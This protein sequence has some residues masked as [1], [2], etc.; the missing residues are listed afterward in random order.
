ML[1][2]FLAFILHQEVYNFYFRSLWI[3][4]VTFSG[5]ALYCQCL[6]L[7]GCQLPFIIPSVHSF[8]GSRQKVN[9]FWQCF[10]MFFC[11]CSFL[12]FVLYFP[13]SFGCWAHSDR[14]YYS[15]C[16]MSMSVL[17]YWKNLTK[18]S[19]LETFL[20][21]RILCSLVLILA[22]SPVI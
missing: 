7:C 5:L 17:T 14:L 12:S 13:V 8:T 6:R 15:T 3:I 20:L 10:S 16:S 11:I 19:T 2:S 21:S 9:V 22:L 4:F 1:M 18:T